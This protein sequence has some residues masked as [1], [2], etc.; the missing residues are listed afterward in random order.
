MPSAAVFVKKRSAFIS[1]GVK[2]AV[3]HDEPQARQER[4][5]ERGPILT[6]EALETWILSNKVFEEIVGESI[7]QDLVSKSSIILVFLGHRRALTERHIDALWLATMK[8]H[9]AVVRVL[10]QMILL[11]VPVLE[12]FLRM[13][14]F[15]LISAVP[16]K[17]YTEQILHLIKSYTL[18]ALAAFRE[19]AVNPLKNTVIASSEDTDTHSST[20]SNTSQGS[21]VRNSANGRGSSSALGSDRVAS[22]SRK[23]MVVSA[24][25]RQWLGFG[26]LWQ[27]IQV[28]LHLPSGM[29]KN[30]HPPSCCK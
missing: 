3:V 5:R 20:A 15:T 6:S 28:M 7:H 17:D 16:Y 4:E 23:G 29:K 11:I 30:G 18:H 2:G 21:G 22:V 9:E 10:H 14:L 25:Q 24:P 8:A 1:S 19:D 12:P 27:F 26:V 13:H